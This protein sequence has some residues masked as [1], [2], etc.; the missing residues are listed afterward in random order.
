MSDTMT[1]MRARWINR[2][3]AWNQHLNTG[4]VRAT[5]TVVDMTPAELLVELHE[6]GGRVWITADEDGFEVLEDRALDVA[7]FRD[8]EPAGGFEV[9]DAV[10]WTPYYGAPGPVYGHIAEL[11]PEALADGGWA[12]TVRDY[13]G[14]TFRVAF[15]RIEH[16]TPDAEATFGG[17][18]RMSGVKM[19]RDP[20]GVVVA[21][22]DNV[23]GQAVEVRLSFGTALEAAVW[24]HEQMTNP[25]NDYSATR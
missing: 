12:A 18:D 16:R 14:A 17:R 25:A 22:Y 24:L 5:G 23:T 21:A 13:D 4:T 15:D 7:D 20:R 8:D 3:V 6:D 1:E 10:R 11:H 2:R 9:G 19:T